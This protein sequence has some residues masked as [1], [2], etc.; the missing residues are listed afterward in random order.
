MTIIDA[1]Y[2]VTRLE[3]HLVDLLK[4]PIVQRLR[5][6]RLSNIDSIDMPGIANI[7][8][9]EHALGTAHLAS[10]VGFLRKLSA[11]DKQV[12]VAAALLHDAAITPF[13]HL[14]EEALQYVSHPFAHEQKLASLL[15]DRASAA[16]LGGVDTQILH[17]RE[18]G[19]HRWASKAFGV[20]ADTR[21]AE[22]LETI[23]GAGTFGPCVAGDIDLDNLDNVARI[24]HH[25]GLNIGRGLG[26]RIASSMDVSSALG[27]E[28]APDAV[29]LIREWLRLRF[30]VYE[31]LMLARQDFAGK[32]MLTAATIAA[33]SRGVIRPMDWRHTD[34]DFLHHLV[35]SAE[36]EVAEPV[37][38]WLSGDLW[39]VTD[40]VWFAG[41][42]PGFPTVYAF[43]EVISR[44][45]HRPCFAYRIKD[46]RN[47]RI[48]VRISGGESLGLGSEPDQW[49]LGVA[50]PTRRDFSAADNKKLVSIASDFFASTCRGKGQSAA[51]SSMR[52]FDLS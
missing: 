32:T 14:V 6:V 48:T 42:A 38:C 29:D 10:H 22:V 28:F 39:P 27:V 43:N 9:Y 3:P 12:V 21:L 17:G 11:A 49:L 47:R 37:K 36:R 26:I 33:V 45:L 2:G 19:L 23:E 15:V 52:L 46:K 1:L 24:A 16:E 25:M 31:R 13:G 35:N 7:S 5:H 20:D 18:S 51:E 30:A 8:R 50:S 41:K 4:L 34:N 40:L 44:A